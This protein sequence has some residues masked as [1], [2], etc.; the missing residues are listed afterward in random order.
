MA[1]L[2][3]SSSYESNP[4]KL[5]RGVGKNITHGYFQIVGMGKHNGKKEGNFSKPLIWT[6]DVQPLGMTCFCVMLVTFIVAIWLTHIQY[7]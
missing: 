7:V 1:E 6:T 2:M 5:P 3:N 4:D